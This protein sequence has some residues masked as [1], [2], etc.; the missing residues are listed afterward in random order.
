VITATNDYALARAILA[1]S[2]HAMQKH[3]RRLECAW[4]KLADLFHHNVHF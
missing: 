3:L 4:I 1:G 2:K